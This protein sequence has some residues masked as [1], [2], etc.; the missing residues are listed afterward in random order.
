MAPALIPESLTHSFYVTHNGLCSPQGVQPPHATV[1]WSCRC[2]GSCLLHVG[3]DY[4]TF[5]LRASPPSG[6]D[7][8][9]PVLL[10][11]SWLQAVTGSSALVGPC[12]LR[13]ALPPP[14]PGTAGRF[15]P[16]LTGEGAS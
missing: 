13:S 1:A 7:G 3:G 12:F 14:A 15:Q 4:G 9:A 16:Q 2:S 8:M 5:S 6:G 11:L 10:P